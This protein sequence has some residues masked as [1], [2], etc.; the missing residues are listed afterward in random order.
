MEMRRRTFFPQ[1]AGPPEDRLAYQAVTSARILEQTETAVRLQATQAR[2]EV[3]ALAPDLFRV[4]MFGGGR[5]ISYDSDAVAKQDWPA[6]EAHLAVTP[7]GVRIQ[8]GSVLAQISLDPF[9]IAFRD[10]GREFAA[11]DD[12]LGMGSAPLAPRDALHVNPLGAP[13][14]VF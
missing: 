14:V 13:S 10:G 2:V 9:R 12:V 6:V 8:M 3:T 4:G 5:P 7:S 1:L 11:D